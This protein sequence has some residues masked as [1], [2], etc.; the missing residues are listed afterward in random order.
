MKKRLREIKTEKVRVSYDGGGERRV[1]ARGFEGKG[2][3]R[4]RRVDEGR[5]GNLPQAFNEKLV[6]N[7]GSRYR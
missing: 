2:G 6:H 5:Q 4:L 1:K 3:R 7:K